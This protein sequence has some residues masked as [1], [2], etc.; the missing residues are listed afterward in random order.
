MIAAHRDHHGA[1]ADGRP[2]LGQVEVAVA[3]VDLPGFS[4]LTEIC[5][6]REATEL[7]TGLANRRSG[8]YNRV[9]GWSRP[10]TMQ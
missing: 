10:S 1:S 8:R 6:D 5:G 2:S 3:F 9:P 4:V 7:A